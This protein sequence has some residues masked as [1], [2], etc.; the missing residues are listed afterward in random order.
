MKLCRRTLC[1]RLDAVRTRLRSPGYVAM[2]LYIAAFTLD[3]ER[4][5]GYG[6]AA[7]R[8]RLASPCG[9]AATSRCTGSVPRDW[10]LAAGDLSQP[11]K[12]GARRLER[13]GTA[14][15]GHNWF[16]YGALSD[17]AYTILVTDT[18]RGTRKTS[19]NPQGTL[20]GGADTAT[21]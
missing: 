4:V 12:R 3:T 21:F 19:R 14:L 17:V 1:Q 18:V 9:S 15:N 16:F 6:V 10:E 7:F 11:W 20:C 8:H 5:K 13:D 2:Y